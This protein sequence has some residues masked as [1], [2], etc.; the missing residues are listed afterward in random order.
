[1]QPYLETYVDQVDLEL[2]E[3]C[4]PLL[5]ERSRIKV[6]AIMP[7][8]IFLSWMPGLGMLLKLARVE[9]SSLLSLPCEDCQHG[10]P[11]LDHGRLPFF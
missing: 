6:C 10:S 11:R 2:T 3:I 4:L 7:G 9:P 5:L 1:M 8:W